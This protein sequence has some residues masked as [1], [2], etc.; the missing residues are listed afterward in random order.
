MHRTLD[1]RSIWWY[2]RDNFSYFSFKLYVVTLHLNRLDETVQMMGHNICFYAELT[3]IIPNYY[4]ILPLIKSSVCISSIWHFAKMTVQV[5]LI[6]HLRHI[7]IAACLPCNPGTTMDDT[8]SDWPN[9]SVRP[10]CAE[11]LCWGNCWLICWEEYGRYVL[12]C[13]G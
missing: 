11:V 1:K 10:N 4:Q 13:S 5:Y 2:S 6:M 3:K 8:H 9:G 7:P 12:G